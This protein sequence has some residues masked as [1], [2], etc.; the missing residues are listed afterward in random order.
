MDKKIEKAKA[1]KDI[2]ALAK[3]LLKNKNVSLRMQA[4]SALGDLGGEEAFDFLVKALYDNEEMVS[5][6]AA[7]ALALMGQEKAIGPLLQ[8]F[9]Q[10]AIDTL[11]AEWAFK[12][13]G[14]KAFPSIIA[15]YKSSNYKINLANLIIGLQCVDAAPLIKKDLEKGVFEAYDTRF[16]RFFVEKHEN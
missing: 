4:A 12:V 14:E 5:R 11:G 15:A 10:C 1:K 3:I 16:L 8:A 7:K 13:I 2:K 9:E 6:S